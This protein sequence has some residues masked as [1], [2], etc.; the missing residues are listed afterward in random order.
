MTQADP[1]PDRRFRGFERAGALV[2]HRIRAA[3]ETR[4]FAVSRV[5]THWDEIVG[6]ETASRARPVKV[7]Y[8]PKGLGATLTVLTSGAWAPVV[9]MQKES[10]RARV[11]AA[12]GYGAISRI[13]LTQTAPT[14]FNEGQRPFGAAVPEPEAD[15]AI[16][17]VAGAAAGAVRD[18]DLRAALEGL[19]RNI[20]SRSKAKEDSR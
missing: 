18:P 6:P 12:Y 15:P 1:K 8:P 19:A 4:G 14:G 13:V 17:A 9:E 11:N 3:G 7:T 10:I 20:L 5:L 16:Q 2:A